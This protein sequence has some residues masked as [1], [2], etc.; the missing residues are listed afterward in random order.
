VQHAIPG[1]QHRVRIEQLV[2]N[3]GVGNAGMLDGEEH[4]FRPRCARLPNGDIIPSLPA[5]LMIQLPCWLV[6]QHRGG[7]SRK[8]AKFA[9]N[10]EPAHTRLAGVGLSSSHHRVGVPP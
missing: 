1:Q 9:A 8:S 10:R 3:L 5:G 7:T 6:I 2:E 4:E